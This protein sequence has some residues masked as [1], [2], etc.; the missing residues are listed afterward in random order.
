MGDKAV[1]G[2]SW[3]VSNPRLYSFD[4]K[5]GE[6]PCRIEDA[7]EFTTSINADD[8]IVDG[9]VMFFLGVKLN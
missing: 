1:G 5:T 3:V 6:S 9:Q 4:T 2:R 8:F 7:M